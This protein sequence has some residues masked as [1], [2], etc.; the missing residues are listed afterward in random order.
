MKNLRVYGVLVNFAVMGLALI[1]VLYSVL[2]PLK[3]ALYDFD[4]DETNT[5]QPHER[6]IVVAIDEYSIDQIGQFPWPREIYGALIENMNQPGSEASVIGFDIMFDT[7]S[8]PESDAAF[9]EAL[10]RYDNVILPSTAVM[11]NELSRTTTVERDKLIPAHGVINPIPALYDVSKHAHINA[12]YDSDKSIRRTWLQLQTPE[13]G[14]LNSL[15]FQSVKMAGADVDH[16]LKYNPQTEIWIDYDAESYDFFTVP[17][18]DVLNGNFPLEN[19]KDAIVLVGFTAVGLSQNDIGVV[20]IEKEMKLVYAHANIVNQLLN[21]TYITYP[22]DW[23]VLVIGFV[24]LLI[25]VFVT[26]RFKTVLSLSLVLAGAVAILVGQHYLFKF[27]NIF[28]DTVHPA[29]IILLTY[30]ANIAVKAFFE[31][32]QKNFITKQFGRYISPDLVKEIASSNQEIQLGG[33][34]KELSILFLDIRGFTTLSER[35][36]PEEVVDFLNKMF[37]LITEKCLENKGTIDKFIGDAAML[38]FN[39]PLDL[40]NH[41]Y[42]AVKTAYDIQKGMEEVRRS[43]FEKYEVTVNV[44]IGIN[45]GE[46]VVGNI[47]SYIRVDYTA[48]GDNVNIAARIESNTTAGQIL[49]SETT[50]ERTKD[51]FEYNCVGER[52]MKGKTVAVKLYEVLGLKSDSAAAEAA[53]GTQ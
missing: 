53:A 27:T 17:F 33:M 2:E 4:M 18:V 31:Q 39:A 35:L 44:G 43:I 20:P 1:L 14:V 9:A 28:I 52:M 38:M 8:N 6:I 19:F 15:A 41:E 36:K 29:A 24:L 13:D 21:N 49:V 42:Y 32:K 30:I 23:V 46:V 5:G 48:I 45:T 3:N 22:P 26:W 16:F 40:P 34:N 51:L 50:Y 11:E 12:V 37:N 10:S 7:E 47:G 25:V